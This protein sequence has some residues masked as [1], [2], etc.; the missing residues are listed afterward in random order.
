MGYK[1]FGCVGK[2]YEFDHLLLLF[3]SIHLSS[4]VGCSGWK[5]INDRKEI[6]LLSNLTSQV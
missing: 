6:G 2:Y 3:I 4:F 1:R 5:G